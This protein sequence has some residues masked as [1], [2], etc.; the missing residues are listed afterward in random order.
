MSLFAGAAF[1]KSAAGLDDLPVSQ[2]EIAF[3]GRSNAGKSSAINTLAGK[4]LAFV[5]KMPGRT[6]LL[7]FYALGADR[8][9]VDLPG[10]GYS[11]AP[12]ATRAL[13]E[14]TLGAYLRTRDPLR[15]AAVIMDVR[16]PLTELDQRMLQWFRPTG[17]PVHVLLSKSDKLSRAA[18]RCAL[19]KVEA[20]LVRLAPNFSAQLFSSLRKFGI[21]EAEAVFSGWLGARGPV[22]ARDGRPA[23]A[24]EE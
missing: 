21:E 5:S 23:A 1:F 20:E 14:G 6:Q 15:G 7:N 9:L 8:F 18:A 12:A 19:S 13:W 3:V 2:G 24:P 11:T 17:K 16:R 22:P 10:Y 4:R